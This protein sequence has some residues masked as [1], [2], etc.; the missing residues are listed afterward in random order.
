MG[1]I[2][3]R[4]WLYGGGRS[5]ARVLAGIGVDSSSPGR[6]AQTLPFSGGD[7]TC[8]CENELQAVVIGSRQDV[9][10]PQTI[11]NSN[12]FKNIIKRHSRGELPKKVITE[13]ENWLG[14]NPG[15]VWE[16]SWVRLPREN[17]CPLAQAAFEA[18]LAADKA[19]PE[20]GK[21]ADAPRFTL[22]RQGREFIR[23]PVSYLLKLALTDI[24]GSQD[25]QP[26]LLRRIGLHYCDNYLCDNTSP[27]L[28]SF[29]VSDLGKDSGMGRAAARETAQRF[30]LTQLLTMHAEGKMG[31]AQCGQQVRAYFAPHPPVRQKRLNEFI[32]DAFYRQLFM[33]P[34][35]AGWDRGEQKHQYMHLCH[36]VLS[37]AQLN[38][39]AR[40]REAGIITNNL[41]VLPNASN[42][43]LANNGT[44][45]TLGSKRL[46]AALAA[47]DER[48]NHSHEKYLGDLV[49]KFMEHFLPLFVGAYSAAP[50]RLGFHDFH[51]ERVLSFLPYELDYTHLR[52]IWRRWK[53]KASL[54][55]RPL[56]LRL[57]PFGP[58]L[59]DRGLAKAF[60]LR[61]DILPDFRLIDYMAAVMSTHQS[62]ALDGRLGNLDRL[63]Q[64][65]AQ[66]SVFDP[67]MPPYMLHRQREFAAMGFSGFEGRH[68]SLF[69]SLENDLGKAVDMQCLLT[70]LA[71]HF[72]AKGALD[73]AHIP[74]DPQTESERRQIFFGAAIGLPTFFVRADTGNLLLRMILED[75]RGVRPSR[76]YPGYIRVRHWQY[77]EALLKLIQREGA[78]LIEAMGLDDTVR[79]L[80]LRLKYPQ[81]TANGRLV[82][83]IMGNFRADDPLKVLPREFNAAAEK[84]YRDELRIKHVNE[85]FDLVGRGLDADALTRASSDPLAAEALDHALG[86]SAPQTLLQ[87]MRAKMLAQS[88]TNGDITRLVNLLLIAAHIDAGRH[89]DKVAPN[90]FDEVNNGPISAPVH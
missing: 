52:M 5:P 4:G 88:L 45:V 81:D 26:E 13:L 17:L 84:Y 6:L 44:H 62:P 72:I 60:G 21:R 27:E 38:A 61:G 50:Y 46:S 66:L 3:L 77:R 56:G 39:V 22:R 35:L 28:F 37:R 47:G 31:L 55:L 58:P 18:D 59:L 86:G 42:I 23:V 51:P 25:G 64:D 83:G 54:K 41:V 90:P 89:P 76:R 15:E 48:F 8:G 20:V 34:C 2:P 33:N 30:L 49:T 69:E 16:N 74:D 67:R 87:G 12:Y 75:T 9:D 43:S 70:A 78:A 32:T 36:K 71:F 24:V 80:R 1:A 79:D 65:L 11:E 14:D 73:H 57:T 29:Y 68:Y 19:H 40:L 63:K 53:K 7:A 82:R 85:A 10:L